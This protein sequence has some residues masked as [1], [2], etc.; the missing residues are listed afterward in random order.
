MYAGSGKE[1]CGSV[2]VETTGVNT[3]WGRVTGL[4]VLTLGAVMQAG[5]WRTE[6]CVDHDIINGAFEAARHF[7]CVM[8]LKVCEL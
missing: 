4:P 5:P 8:W 6:G 2:V 1:G 3:G 7:G